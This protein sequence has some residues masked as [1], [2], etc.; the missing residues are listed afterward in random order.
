M[1]R[2]FLFLSILVLLSLACA[3]LTNQSTPQGP[4]VEQL[5]TRVA[6]TLT[7]SAS[8]QNAPSK[9]TP[10]AN[11]PQ[12]PTAIPSITAS[13]KATATPSLTV[14]ATITNTVPPTDTATPK[15]TATPNLTDPAVALGAPSYKDTFDT[16]KSWYTV[17]DS[18]SKIEIKDSALV[19]TAKTLGYHSW[20]MEF[21]K[22]KNAYMEAHF[23]TGNCSGNDRYGL[24]FR[25]GADYNSGYFLN[26]TCSGQ[27]SL[28]K[29]DGSDFKKL[30]DP[31]AAPGFK[32]GANQ[33]NRLGVMMIEDTYTLYVN[34]APVKEV[35]DKSYLD[36]GLYGAFIAAG[37]T[38]GF[39]IKM[40]DISYWLK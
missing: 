37:A 28:N 7:A 6:Q 4:Q 25:G 8:Q 11:A 9:N 20:S 13:L 22:V 24:I 36:D 10:D 32:A 16:S 18:N 5:G 15:P 14:T 12:L 31:M 38:P 26:V 23:T 19:L 30:L 1:R 17:D 34:G 29:Y 27:L 21:R 40:E 39:T 3:T 35:K 2:L 33:T